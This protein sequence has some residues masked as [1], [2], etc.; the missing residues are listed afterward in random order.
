MVELEGGLTVD[1]GA[2]SAEDGTMSGGDDLASGSFEDGTWSSSKEDMSD[3][4]F[5][6]VRS[7]WAVRLLDRRFRL[8]GDSHTHRMRKITGFACCA[9]LGQMATT[10]WLFFALASGTFTAAIMPVVYSAGSMTLSAYYWYSKGAYHDIIVHIHLVFIALLPSLMHVQLGGFENSGHQIHFAFMAPAFASIVY[11][12]HGKIVGRYMALSVFVVLVCTTLTEYGLIPADSWLFSA[13]R[14]ISHV[15]STISYQFSLIAPPVA[16]ALVLYYYSKTMEMLETS[17]GIALQ[18]AKDALVRAEDEK[19][20]N[21]AKTRFVSVMS[22]EI[23]N[24]LTGIVLNAELLNGTN[25]NPHQQDYCLGIER[26]SQILL[27]IVN[28]VLD[29]TKIESGSVTLEKVPFNLREATE[30]V[31]HTAAPAAFAKGLEVVLEC[32]ARA[33]VYVLG[34]PTRYRQVIHNL[35]GNA[36][37]FTRHGQIVVKL[38]L[39]KGENPYAVAGAGLDR[40]GHASG[41][42]TSGEG[43]LSFGGP[44]SS[45]GAGSSSSAMN[46]RARRGRAY[47]GKGSQSADDDSSADASKSVELTGSTRQRWRV[48]VRDSGIGIGPEGRRKLFQEFSQVDE[49]TTREYGGTG[50]G[51]FIC[52]QL[53]NLMG[54]QIGVKSQPGVGSDFSFTMSLD[55]D[56]AYDDDEPIVALEASD[57]S[58]YVV[59]AVPN[60]ELSRALTNMLEYFFNSCSVRIQPCTTARAAI[61]L[62][63]EEAG[64]RAKSQSDAAATRRANIVLVDRDIS[65]VALDERVMAEDGTFPILLVADSSAVEREAIARAGWRYLVAKPPRLS[66]VC[67]IMASVCSDAAASSEVRGRRGDPSVVGESGTLTRGTRALTYEPGPVAPDAPIV[68]L[69]DDMD[70]VRN[71]VRSVV[72]RLGYR[73]MVAINGKEAVEAYASAWQRESERLEDRE[74]ANEPSLRIAL[75]LMD[76]EMPVKDGRTAARD[77]RAWEKKRE[78]PAVAIC[79]MTANAMRDDVQLCVEAG[80]NDFMSKPVSQNKLLDVLHRHCPITSVPSLDAANAQPV[81][82]EVADAVESLNQSA[83]ST[84]SDGAKAGSGNTLKATSAS[85]R[86]K[87]KKQPGHPDKKADNA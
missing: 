78:V 7:V 18:N 14:P 35:I 52:R 84:K 33:P 56:T 24:P 25:L 10:V 81:N 39:I 28:N 46:K 40:A 77:I 71:L 70:L 49:S 23:R 45:T 60:L 4:G 12:G 86:R 68:M 38:Q 43:G 8:A 55:R 26:A 83:V 80:M 30:F 82:A 16:L 54:G 5:A 64:R 36:L 50:L 57:V 3:A 62:L 85:R 27:S 53:V 20:A 13:A 51:L 19:R 1:G 34:D 44:S 67:T 58:W 11:Q 72:E 74:R 41:G 69:V 79:A 73:T 87:A 32:D 66:Q 9:I 59:L 29:V 65:T 2:A 15:A 22:H 63:D 6:L 61:R 47:R 37:K 21:M 75:I 31:C 48:S 17:R 42:D 76:I